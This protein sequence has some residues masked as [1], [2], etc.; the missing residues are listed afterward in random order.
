MTAAALATGNAVIRQ[1]RRES[2]GCGAKIVEALHAAGFPRMCSTCFLEKATSARRS[3][4]HPAVHTIAFTGSRRSGLEILRAAAE[5]APGQQHIK[6]VVAELGGKNCVIVAAD[7]D[8]DEAVPAIV[9]SAFAYAGQK[10]SAAS[11]VLVCDPVADALLERLAGA[12]A[13][14]RRRPGGSAH[15]ADP[16]ADRGR[17]PGP[18]AKPRR[19]GGTEGRSSRVQARPTRGATMPSADGLRAAIQAPRCSA[20]S[21]S[22][23]C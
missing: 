3:W 7:A 12:A 16:A 2:P 23:P 19:A 14:A 1:A 11:R 15:D 18:P 5:L 4:R 13:S 6:R 9:D 10:C 17:R 21:C 8:L 22:A 20:T